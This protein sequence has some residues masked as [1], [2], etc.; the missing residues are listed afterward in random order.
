MASGL[1]NEYAG[2]RAYTGN[3]VSG[4]MIRPTSR[5]DVKSNAMNAGRER[6]SGPWMRR[7]PHPTTMTAEVSSVMRMAA[8]RMVCCTRRAGPTSRT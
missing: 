2:S 8:E 7:P 6:G 5:P 4:S 3:S 1:V